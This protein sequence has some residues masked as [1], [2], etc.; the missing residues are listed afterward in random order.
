M[1]NKVVTCKDNVKNPG[2]F[3]EESNC[4]GSDGSGPQRDG[5]QERREVVTETE[6][7]EE[8]DKKE[9]WDSV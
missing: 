4:E 7:D 1:N 8:S 6:R 9:E 2:E 5:E 3:G